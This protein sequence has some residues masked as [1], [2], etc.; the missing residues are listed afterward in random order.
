MERIRRRE[1][2]AENGICV[3]PLNTS[4]QIFIDFGFSR[5]MSDKEMSKLVRQMGRVWGLQKR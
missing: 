1:R 4:L 2:R 5:N 3:Q